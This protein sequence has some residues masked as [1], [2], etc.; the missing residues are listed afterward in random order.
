LRR[1]DQTNADSEVMTAAR[2]TMKAGSRTSM[3]GDSELGAE[4]MFPICS[5]H[6]IGKLL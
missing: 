2:A 1:T 4:S 5:L 6:A 3:T